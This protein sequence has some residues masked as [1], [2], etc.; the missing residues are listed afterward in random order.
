[1]PMDAIRKTMTSDPSVSELSDLTGA[2]MRTGKVVG[3]CVSVH[4]TEWD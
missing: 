3:I 2:A 1:M 4:V